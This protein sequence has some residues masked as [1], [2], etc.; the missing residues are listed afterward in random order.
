MA[1]MS[2][3][4]SAQLFGSEKQTASN[5]AVRISQLEEQIRILTGQLEELSFQVRS[6]EDTLRRSQ[7]DTEYRL[8]QL[9]GTGAGKKQ[10]SASKPPTSSQRT[11]RQQQVASANRSQQASGAGPLDLSAQRPQAKSS[12]ASST[13]AS[14]APV[15][16]FNGNIQSS[17]VGEPVADYNMI[18]EVLES[19]NYPVAQEGFDTFLGMYPD[20]KLSQNAQF[21]Y[22]ESLYGQR[23]YRSAA[24]AFL[25][26]YTDY[27]RGEFAA[28]SLLKLGISLKGL[29]ESGAACATFS[30]LLT[31]FP[32]AP[33]DLLK[34]V[35][36]EQASARC[37]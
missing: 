10:S 5:N 19:G 24:D 4:A 12:G 2:G 36:I 30:E 20:H 8:Q 28:E 27:P 22:G 26:S 25:K 15:A 34:D 3:A 23:Q 9:E 7:E 37:N 35:K 29:G 21:W 6:L 17:L 18:Y 13:I 33:K 14:T 32:N 11:S 31:K 1:L 16:H